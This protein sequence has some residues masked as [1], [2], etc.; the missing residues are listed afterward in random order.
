MGAET[1][2]HVFLR[3][4]HP[5]EKDPSE[6][7]QICNGKSRADKHSKISVDSTNR[8]CISISMTLPS[9][10]SLNFLVFHLFKS[11]YYHI[12]YVAA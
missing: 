5:L 2:T 4:V 9:L 8:N 1:Q 10:L 11:K 12:L 7:L 6:Q 3:K